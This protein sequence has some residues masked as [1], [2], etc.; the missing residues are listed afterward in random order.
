MQEKLHPTAD[1]QPSNT[2]GVKF[3]DI[4]PPIADEIV[5][6]QEVS[7]SFN[8]F[9]IIPYSGK[10]QQSSH[11]LVG[12][13]WSFRNLSSTFAGVLKSLK[14]YCLNGK[15]EIVQQTDTVFQLDDEREVPMNEKVQFRDFLNTLIFHNSSIKQ[16]SYDSLDSLK[17]TGQIGVEVIT[18]IVLGEKKVIIKFHKPTEYCFKRNKVLGT[19]VF[20]SKHWNQDYL[21]K[22]PPLEVPVYPLQGQYAGQVTRTFFYYQENG[23][24]YGR[25][26][27]LGCLWDK[28]NEFKTK[29]YLTKKSRGMFIPDLII[30]TADEVGATGFTNEQQAKDEGYLNAAQKFEKKFTNS[31]QNPMNVIVTNRPSSARPME[32]I[33]LEGIKGSAEVKGYLDI[34]KDGILDANNWTRM[35]LDFNGATG[36]STN[37]YFDIF[38]I[39]SVTVIA[40]LQATITGY[41]NNILNYCFAEQELENQLGIKYT[42]RIQQLLD[43]YNERQRSSVTLPKSEGDRGEN[44]AD[45]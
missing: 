7:R 6:D 5:D 32:V 21:K 24:L 12:M 38:N 25:P 16:L 10:Q 40:D 3:I 4:S 42:S 37:T 19:A 45:M 2:G 33:Q 36:F 39:V 35:L 43:E 9:P 11:K 13:L 34:Y 14:T 1:L 31:G 22:N 29:E 41:I 28:Y 17:C 20:I 44:A 30:E 26:S 8:E 23:N 15:I 18:K 27:D